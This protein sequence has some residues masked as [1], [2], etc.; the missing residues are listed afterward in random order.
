ML[1]RDLEREVGR[2]M[3]W[4]KGRDVWRRDGKGGDRDIRGE[5]EGDTFPLRLDDR[6]GGPPFPFERQEGKGR[7]PVPFPLKGRK[8]PFPSLFEGKAG[9]ALSKQREGYSL[10][11]LCSKGNSFPLF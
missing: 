2:Y 8:A 4:G 7:R 11:S 6:E 10:L 1:G 9:P 3:G 5:G